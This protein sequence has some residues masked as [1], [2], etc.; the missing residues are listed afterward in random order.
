MNESD[1]N[2][3]PLSAEDEMIF[4]AQSFIEK[5]ISCINLDKQQLISLNR[6]TFALERIPEITTGIDIE[7]SISLRGGDENSSEMRYWQ[8]HL[9]DIFFEIRSG[10]SVY[11]KAVGSDT[12][13]GYY[14]YA[15]TGGH[16]SYNGDVFAWL[17]EAE[18]AICLNPSLRI[19]DESECAS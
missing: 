5:I 18:E 19:D 12:I 3:F 15:E 2:I 10:G 7:V 9:S 6:I 14:F 17:D 16:L 11:D 13:D 4:A 1:N 8:V